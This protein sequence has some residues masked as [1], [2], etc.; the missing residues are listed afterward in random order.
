M[1]AFVVAVPPS[2][3]LKFCC[4]CTLGLFVLKTNPPGSDGR[5]LRN[6]PHSI[7]GGGFLS[8]K[9]FEQN[10]PTPRLFGLLH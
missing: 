8:L 6:K 3:G 1:E 7:G 5:I 9:K 10:I 2:P 4:I